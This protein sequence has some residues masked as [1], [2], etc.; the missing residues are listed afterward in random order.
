[1][2]GLFQL[3]DV[4][5]KIDKPGDLADGADLLLKTKTLAGIERSP[6]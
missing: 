4:D 6:D 5:E 2:T 3:K 1:M